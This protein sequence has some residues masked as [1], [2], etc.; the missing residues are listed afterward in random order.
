MMHPSKKLGSIHLVLAASLSAIFAG[1]AANAVE[2]QATDQAAIAP[3]PAA[4]TECIRR[5]DDPTSCQPKPVGPGPGSGTGNACY[6]RPDGNYG[7][8]K[9]CIDVSECVT[10]EP[11]Y[12][13]WQYCGLC[14]GVWECWE[15]P[16]CGGGSCVSVGRQHP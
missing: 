16:T 3:A 10:Q 12:S 6:S 8:T 14:D 5:Y 13:L 4:Q 11:G 9:W 2:T 1:C 15:D 7:S